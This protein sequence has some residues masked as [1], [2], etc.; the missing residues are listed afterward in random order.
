MSFTTF[1]VFQNE[2]NSLHQNGDYS[3]ALEL[4]KNNKDRFPSKEGLINYWLITLYALQDEKK[5][6]LEVLDQTVATG[7]W[8][9]D[10]LLRQNADLKSLQEVEQFESLFVK[11][12]ENRALDENH[13]FPL[14][15]L[16]SENSCQSI[17]TPC[18][19]LLA[20]HA[21]AATAAASLDFWRAA[22]EAGYLVAAP[23]SSQ[24]L[25][26]GAYVWEDLDAS[27]TEIVGHL[28]SLIEKYQIDLEETIISGIRQGS[29]LCLKLAL[30]GLIQAKGFILF[31]PDL[32]FI[33]RSDLFTPGNESDQVESDLRGYIITGAA[34]ERQSENYLELFMDS[35]IEHG[36]ICN[37]VIVPDAGNT[38]TPEYDTLLLR[39]IDNIKQ[40]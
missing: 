16:R 23:Q 20:I 37:S 15:I 12:A 6:A 33:T 25:W 11:N 2:V 9:S 38:Y 5:L 10:F 26:K 18:P 21:N 3:G 4:I 31:N 24:A 36:I 22:T 1:E 30:S 8:Y 14:L 7:F 28:K 29:E 19:L 27:T 40:V 17:E 39:A 34:S 32:S 35:M 13:L